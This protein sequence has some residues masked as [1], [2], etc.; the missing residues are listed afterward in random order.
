MAKAGFDKQIN[1][2]LRVRLT[3]SY[4]AQPTAVSNILYAGDRAGSRYYMVLEN[5]AAT[6]S[7][8]P[9]S[10]NINPGFSYRSTS[11]VVNPFIKFRGLE[12]FGM[13]ETATGRGAAETSE[14][15]VKQYMAEGLYR[16]AANDK[17]YVGARW[18]SVQGDLGAAAG[19][20]VTVDRVNVGG[21]WFVT[22]TLMAKVELVKQSYSGFLRTDIR[23]GAK[24]AGLMME[25]VVAF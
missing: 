18:N 3:G 13:A 4:R 6:E 24:F 21:G 20:D 16:F 22:P 14:R 23:N 12:F 8:Q 7:A 5:S 25:G 10:G 1:S 19:S 17:F 15:T 2:D 11:F 9:Y